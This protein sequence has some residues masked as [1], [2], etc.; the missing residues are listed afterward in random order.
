M[1]E[2]AKG[3]AV[4]I[5]MIS[6]RKLNSLTTAEKVKLI[7]D[8][9]VQGKVVIL[10]RGLNPFEEARLI[11]STMARVDEAFTGIEM[12]SYPHAQKR[13]L[14]DRLLG[15]ERQRMTVIGPADRLRTLCREHDLITALIS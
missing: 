5:D 2:D 7:L 1:K 13:S 12:K 14:L 6:E 11:E 9:V 10:E 4:E 3:D 8:A 15:T